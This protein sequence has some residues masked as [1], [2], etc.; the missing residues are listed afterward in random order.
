MTDCDAVRVCLRIRPQIA[1]EK[2][3]LCRVCT[4]AMPGE[5]QV[6]LGT[7]RAFTFDHVFD[8]QSRQEIIYETCTG[9]GK[10]YT[11]GTSFDSGVS[12]DEEGIVPRAVRQLFTCISNNRNQTKDETMLADCLVEVQFIELY[13][14]EILDLLCFDGCESR[15]KKPTSI[16]IHEDNNGN[17]YLSDVTK[18]IVNSAEQTMQI[19]KNGALNRTTASTNMNSQSSRSHAI[20]TLSLRQEK[21]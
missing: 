21:K 1:R 15:N 18:V 5:P 8:V 17:I 19:L 9:S 20:F 7:D 12:E 6:L 3:E 16:K 2:L 4:S 13:N 10:T 14:E 11:M